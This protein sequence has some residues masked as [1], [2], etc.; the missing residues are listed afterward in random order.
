MNYQERFKQALKVNK[1]PVMSVE[2][3]E[4]EARKELLSVLT[5]KK[6]HKFLKSDIDGAGTQIPPG[7]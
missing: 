3:Q 1:W 4:K 7:G 2:E 6:Q 5:G